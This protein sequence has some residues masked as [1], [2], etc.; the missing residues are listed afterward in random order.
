MTLLVRDEVDIIEAHLAF[1]LHAGV[2]IV[3]ATDHGSTD[4]TTEVLESYARDGHVHLIR[5]ADARIRQSEWVTQMARSAATEHYADW[6]INS[7][8]DEFWWPQGGTLREVLAMIPDRYGVVHAVSRYFVPRPADGLPFGER[9]NVR[10]AAPAPINDPATPFRPVSKVAHR[11]DMRVVVHKGNHAVEGLPFRSLRGWRP[12]E[13]LHFPLRSPEQC[14]RKYE[15]TWLGWEQNLRGDLARARSL[16]EQARQQFLY[17]RVAVDDVALERGLGTGAL[18]I[19]TRLKDALRRILE[20]EALVFR[21]PSPGADAE[22]ARDVATVGE[23]DAVRLHRRLDEL[24]RRV[25]AVES[26]RAR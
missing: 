12:I 7:D 24:D 9:M 17:S 20:G 13:L 19:D 1:H 22:Y 3:I 2:D 18:V 14:A 8:A 6:V 15:K 5:R 4:G 23:A 25:T 11:A 26:R 10:L 21:P 16:S